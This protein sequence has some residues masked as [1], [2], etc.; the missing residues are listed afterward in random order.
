MKL[1]SE[2]VRSSTE[3]C[4]KHG[5]WVLLLLLAA[6]MSPVAS[7]PSKYLTSF[8]SKKPATE[9]ARYL[10]TPAVEA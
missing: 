9:G 7:A 10:Q 1:Q 2:S 3:L 8:S 6:A 5:K 4:E